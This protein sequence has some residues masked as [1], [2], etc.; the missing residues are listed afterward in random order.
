MRN[1]FT[2]VTG[3][4][5]AGLSVGVAGEDAKKLLQEDLKKFQGTWQCSRICINN[6]DLGDDLLRVTSITIKLKFCKLE[7]TL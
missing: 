7:F 2:I 6:A 5:V 4:L 1:V 3:L